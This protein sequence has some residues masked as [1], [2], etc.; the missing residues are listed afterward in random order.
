MKFEILS[1][2]T[3]RSP[4]HSAPCKHRGVCI[5]KV[6]KSWK[7][8][9]HSLAIFL[10]PKSLG[11]K[12]GQRIPEMSGMRNK[13]RQNCQVQSHL[14]LSMETPKWI[15]L[16][17]TALFLRSVAWAWSPTGV[18]HCLGQPASLT[19]QC[20]QLAHQGGFSHTSIVQMSF[21]K[22]L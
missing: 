21:K 2:Q 9:I 17:K 8:L 4:R 10:L 12:C 7:H 13:V 3:N 6:C 5:P 20:Y 16:H 15:G 18:H 14:Q 1:R 11:Y 19:W 22:T